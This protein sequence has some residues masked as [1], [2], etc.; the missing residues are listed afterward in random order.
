MIS[1]D[2]VKQLRQ[3]TGISV[4]DCKKALTETKGDIEK[5]R[6]VLRKW[7]K[8]FALKK[9]SRETKQGIIET[10]L[11]PN[12][13]VGVMVQVHCETDFVAKSDEFK[14]LAHELCLQIA[15][16]SPLYLK[17][18]EI[19][20]EFLDGEKKI[21]QEQFKNSGKPQKIVD[22]VIEGKL[23]K[24]KEEISLFSQI[25]IKDETKIIKD[26]VE[27][28]IAKLGENI[29]VRRFIRYDF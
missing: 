5:A 6:E 11:H 24:Y 17:S 25:W 13:K 7:G 21:Y 19:P 28:Y 8:E 29:L 20:E 12:G 23:K 2:Q 9:T 4:T 16:M 26:L 15:A 18:D 3:E 1:I 10:Y 22:Q 27:E 14:K